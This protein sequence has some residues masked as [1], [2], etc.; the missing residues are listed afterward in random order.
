MARTKITSYQYDFRNTADE[1]VAILLLLNGDDLLCMAAFVDKEDL[2]A[3]SMGMNGVV[4]ISYHYNWL[5]DVID[6]LRNEEPVYFIWHDEGYAAITTEEEIVGE[7][8]R[9]GLLQFLFGH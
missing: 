9:K 8:E 2:P 4:Y 5:N 6:M 7:E 1:N 3:P